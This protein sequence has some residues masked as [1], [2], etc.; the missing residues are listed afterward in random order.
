MFILSATMLFKLD[1]FIS[2]PAFI[3]VM[4][5]LYKNTQLKYYWIIPILITLLFVIRS[6]DAFKQSILHSYSFGGSFN[7]NTFIST[8]KS[9]GVPIDYGLSLPTWMTRTTGVELNNLMLYVPIL[10]ALVISIIIFFRPIKL[11]SKIWIIHLIFHYVYPH[12]FYNHYYFIVL[13]ILLDITDDLIPHRVNTTYE[14][15]AS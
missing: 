12:S 3:P 5:H 7:T 9:L 1:T 8:Q 2:L 15:S 14:P 11:F 13:M 4:K 6:P 10:I